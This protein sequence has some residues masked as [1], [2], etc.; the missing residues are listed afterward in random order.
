MKRTAALL[1][2]LWSFAVLS[3]CTAGEYPVDTWVKWRES[4]TGRYPQQSWLKYATPEEAGWSSEKLLK[5]REHYDSLN[6]AAVMV[7]YD[8]AV[9]AAW[10]DVRRRFKCHS[11]RKSLLSALYGVHVAGGRIDLNKTLAELKIDD[12]PPLTDR[13]K[14]ARVIDLLK[15]RSGVYHAA[16]YE[17]ARMK[18]S[19]PKRGSHEPGE[20]YWYNNWDFNALCT[21]FEQE[22]GTKVFEEFQRR[23]AAPLELEDFRLQDTYYHLE[24]EHSIHA[25]YPF[26]LSARDMARFGMLFLRQGKWRDRR[27]LTEAWV[28]QSTASHFKKGD[29]TPN[30]QYGYGYL[31]WRIVDGPL[32]E[33]QMASARGYGGHAIDVLPVADLVIVHR[34]DTFWDLSSHLG[35]EKKR[36]K[37]AE[38]FKLLDLILRARVARP[39]PRPKL[40]PLPAA[41]PHGAFVK[42]DPQAARKYTG[43]YD[44]KHFKLRV[45]ASGDGL[46]VGSAGMGDFSLLPRSRTEFFIEDLEA[47]VT[48]ELDDDG[49]P[50][51]MFGEFAPGKRIEGRRVQ[52]TQ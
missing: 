13:E 28:K 16:A 10:G 42:L 44:F 2:G 8:G 45:K 11:I 32:K 21:I 31:W 27:I 25:A 50:V 26:R 40:V 6:S 18:K 19:R 36:V 43:Q 41:C 15:A 35:R 51:R 37:D 38:R 23:F 1:F 47:P 24:K 46:L 39:K 9:L 7:V 34:V 4:S 30:P 33:L 20:F 5:A 49:R 17:T 48:F 52:G 29:K 3:P 14:R 12:D 22:T